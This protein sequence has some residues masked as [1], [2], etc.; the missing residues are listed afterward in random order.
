MASSLQQGCLTLSSEGSRLLWSGEAD[1]ARGSL[2]AAPRSA[3]AP[4][5][6]PLVAPTLLELQGPRLELVLRGLLSSAALKQ[7]LAD[8]YGIKPDALKRLSQSPF[9]LRLSA[10]NQG[11][12]LAGLQLQ[13]RL[14]DG[15][16]F[17]APRLKALEQPLIDQGL[18]VTR[19]TGQQ[20]L[21][22]RD[23][24]AQGGW[25][26]LSKDQ[27]LLFLGPAPGSLK[28]ARLEQEV[29]WSLRLQP[30]QLQAQGLLPPLMPVVVRRARE[31]VLRGVP[32]RG[33][34]TALSG[35]LTL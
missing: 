21:W 15:Q 7:A 16:A 30:K 1:A 9:V 28:P 22:S 24:V 3:A 26:W 5:P 18:S 14:R 35:E 34:Q 2:A 23:G 29:P 19:G 27:L 17:W 31:L 8:R 32:S 11:S 25:R 4:D 33:G 12:F 6:E 10:L 20:S 13:L